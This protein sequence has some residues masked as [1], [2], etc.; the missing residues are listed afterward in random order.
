MIVN[1]VLFVVKVGVLFLV[2]YF[3][4]KFVVFGWM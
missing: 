3:V 2:Y 4:S 1:I